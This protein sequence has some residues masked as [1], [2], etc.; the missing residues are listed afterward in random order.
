M[1]V[2]RFLAAL[3]ALGCGASAIACEYPPLATIPSGDEATMDEMLEAQS[4]VRVYVGAMEEYLGCVDGELT[5][6]GD[7]APEEFKAVMFSRH[8]AAVAEMEAIANHFNEQIRIF[9]CTS[10][11]EANS[12]DRA[13]DA[14]DECAQVATD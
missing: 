12:S 5:A 10:G 8:N 13:A 9:R 7:D 1:S 3:V 2:L 6:S 4:E 14:I 11:T